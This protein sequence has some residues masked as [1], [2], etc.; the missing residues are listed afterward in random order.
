MTSGHER[1]HMITLFAAAALLLCFPALAGPASAATEIFHLR[2][3]CSKLG[4]QLLG[5]AGVNSE[6]EHAF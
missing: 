1:R 2:T 5:E 3:E 6:K 4:K